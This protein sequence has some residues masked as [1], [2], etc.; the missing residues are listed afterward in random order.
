MAYQDSP[1][2][3]SLPAYQ[4]Y[5]PLS[6]FPPA[7]GYCSTTALLNEGA[8]QTNAN[9]QIPSEVQCPAGDDYLCDLLFELKSSD[10]DFARGVW[11]V[12][13]EYYKDQALTRFL[14]VVLGSVLGYNQRYCCSLNNFCSR[15]DKATC[16]PS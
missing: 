2:V 10:H 9:P 11:Y 12:S 14:A 15:T 6:G 7:L 1:A 13:L 16:R 5:V 4:T 8:D 3:C